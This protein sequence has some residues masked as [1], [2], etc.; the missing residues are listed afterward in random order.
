M[1][2]PDEIPYDALAM[3]AD[4]RAPRE[5]ASRQADVAETSDKVAGLDP[6]ERSIEPDPADTSAIAQRG[7]TYR[8]AGRYDQASARVPGPVI[9]EG[10][11]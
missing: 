10:Q 7:E 2:M 9:G 11:R 3:A 4:R 8:L 1:A 5:A 6:A